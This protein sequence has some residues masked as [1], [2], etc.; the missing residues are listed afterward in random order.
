MDIGV[1]D[2]FRDTIGIRRVVSP[3]QRTLA[4]TAQACQIRRAGAAIKAVI[5][6]RAIAGMDC[7]V[8]LIAQK[9]V[10][11]QGLTRDFI[12]V[13]VSSVIDGVTVPVKA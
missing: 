9:S 7:T 12:P 5:V 1:V 3:S 4:S 10:T 11:P 6:W 2:V 13:D 8:R